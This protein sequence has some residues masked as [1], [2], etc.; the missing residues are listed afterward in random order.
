MQ[1]IGRTLKLTKIAHRSIIEALIDNAPLKSN[2]EAFKDNA[3]YRSNIK[4]DNDY[5]SI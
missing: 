5:S 4:A 3:A 2:V 1:H